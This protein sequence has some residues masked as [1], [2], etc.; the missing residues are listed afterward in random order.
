LAEAESSIFLMLPLLLLCCLLPML[1]R[2]GIG[3]RPLEAAKEFDIWIV[4]LKIGEVFDTIVREVENWRGKVLIEPQKT[5]LP[6]FKLGKETGKRFE[7]SQSIPPRLLRVMD[8]QEGEMVFELTEIEGGGTSVKVSFSP[9]AKPRIQTLKAQ[10][11]A[12]IMTGW[13]SCPFCGKPILPDYN[14]CPYCGQRL[15]VTGGSQN[16]KV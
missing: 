1:M 10:F 4:P 9:P 14:L 2:G 6:F 5:P 13:R 12:K 3:G 15:R 8:R 16:G 7:V 11:P